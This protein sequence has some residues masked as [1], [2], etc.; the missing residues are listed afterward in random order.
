MLLH[1]WLLWATVCDFLVITYI[2]FACWH[3]RRYVRSR[4][5]IVGFAV[6]ARVLV[7]Q[8]RVVVDDFSSLLRC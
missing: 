3:V 2:M 5:V 4:L 1:T 7:I 8:V 6:D